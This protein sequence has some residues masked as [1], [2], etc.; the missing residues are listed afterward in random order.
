MIAASDDAVVG[1]GTPCVPQA[2]GGQSVSAP[3]VWRWYA[4]REVGVPGRRRLDQMIR[5][6]EVMVDAAGNGAGA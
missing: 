5:H 6:A 2:V 3:T 1:D 4:K